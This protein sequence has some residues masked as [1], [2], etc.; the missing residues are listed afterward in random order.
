MRKRTI[1][2]ATGI[3]AVAVIFML[4]SSP[5]RTDRRGDKTRATTPPL[6][7]VAQPE[8]EL[9][10]EEA[11][12]VAMVGNLE[13][14]DGKL[15]SVERLER[16]LALY[17]ETTVYPPWSRPAAE[18]STPHLL[19]PNPPTSM[20]QP[21][22]ADSS[23]RI[24]R[25]DVVLDRSYIAPGEKATAVLTVTRED[26][27]G[28]P[29]EPE[30]A[31]MR[32]QVYDP[33]QQEW[34]TVAELPLRR[35]GSEF[36][37]VI[38]PAA[39]PALAA[40]DPA[41]EV[42]LLAYVKVAEFFKEMPLIFRYSVVQPFEVEAYAGDRIAAGSLEID[43]DVVV[44]HVAPTLIQGVLY[45]ATGTRPIATYE[46][47][48]L[49]TASGPQAVTLQF[50]GKVLRDAEISGPYRLKALHGH[51]LFAER[52]PGEQLWNHPDDPP[53]V[54]RSYASTQFTD[55]VWSSPEKE[56]TVARYR[57][58]IAQGGM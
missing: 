13:T 57:D 38:D 4:R 41:P 33:Q 23:R 10:E 8:P 17:Q 40:A 22:A 5:S 1:L 53:M 45:D 9:N 52:E 36:I 54:T 31:A 19:D 24:V 48:F 32:V 26:Q 2:V 20:G 55:A 7:T 12:L 46:K 6:P 49:P 42:R 16:T 39:I 21:F 51:V 18:G 25:T 58:L 44:H 29:Y 30:Q 3:A 50:Y 37:A 11:A 34:P 47:Q 35:N 28:A 14:V 15:A 56:E 27:P 43:L